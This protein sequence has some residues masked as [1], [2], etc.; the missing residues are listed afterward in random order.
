MPIK[1]REL[2]SQEELWEMF[3]YEPETGELTNI[4]TGHVCGSRQNQGKGRAFHIQAYIDGVPYQAH[5]IIW[6]M[7]NGPIPE[8]MTIDHINL[9]SRDNR[10]S[11]LRLATMRQQMQNRRE[12]AE[13]GVKGV[14]ITPKGKIYSNITVN[15]KTIHIGTFDT[16][17]EAAAAYEQ[18]S[19]KYCGHF[20]RVTS[21][22]SSA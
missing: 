10:L 19:L 15:K 2:P 1:A 13:T 18:A 22:S 12:W 9:D 6:T 21:V 11:N 20:S 7:V 8:G 5:R 3:S 16:V 4:A 17:E 14:Y